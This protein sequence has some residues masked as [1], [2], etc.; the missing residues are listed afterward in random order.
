MSETHLC[1]TKLDRPLQF[2]LSVIKETEYFVITEIND[3]E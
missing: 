3:N 1:D 2:R